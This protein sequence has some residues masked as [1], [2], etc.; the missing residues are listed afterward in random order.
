M[1]HAMLPTVLAVIGVGIS[2]T[3]L[4]TRSR[5]SAKHPATATGVGVGVGVVSTI[6]DAATIEVESVTG[7][8]FAG[9]LRDDTI[10]S[11]LRPGAVLLVAFDPAA[12]ERLS[13]ADDMMAVRA[14]FDQMLVDK[15][16]LTGHQLGLIRHGIRSHSVITG[17]RATGERLEDYREVELDLMVRRPGGGQF[18]VHETALIPASS[19]TKV[20][21]GSVIDTFFRPEDETE[22]AVSVPP[23]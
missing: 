1:P 18:A 2:T 10:T 9:R 14:A 21:P 23:A 20:A 13:L 19:M 7:L 22:V 17:M 11:T 12:R 4:L 16:L 3:L 6:T 15:G 5:A 8:R